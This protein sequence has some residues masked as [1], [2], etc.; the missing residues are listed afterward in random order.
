MSRLLRSRR[1]KVVVVAVAALAIAASA[2]AYW[3]SQGTGSG[4]ATVGTTAALTIKNVAI[5][6]TL[7][8]GGSSAVTYTVENAT[9]SP[10]KFSDVLVDETAGTHGIT[11]L[12]DGCSAADF[13]YTADTP[14][15]GKELAAG[16]STTGSGTLAFAN[17]SDN[18]DACKGAAPVL[19]LKISNGSL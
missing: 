11:G 7:V 1:L 18:Q 16:D 3:T 13:S 12:P 5:A 8:P 19:H 2:Y 9:S 10:V 6:D 15:S 14:A 4:S 17:T